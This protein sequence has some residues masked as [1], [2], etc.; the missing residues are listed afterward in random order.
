M[1]S[2]FHIEPVED[3]VAVGAVD[4]SSA[5]I[6][7]RSEV[8]GRHIVEVLDG[9]AGRRVEVDV[10]TA[11]ERC[12]VAVAVL[13][14]LQPGRR[15]EIV[16]RRP[17]DTTWPERELGR[18]TF[19]TAPASPTAVERFS[20]G[21][22]SCH[23][24]FDENGDV[25]PE[26]RA[27]LA[28]TNR[29]L[30]ERDAAFVLML[31]DQMYSDS[32]SSRSLF[33][34]EHF[35]TVAPKGRDALLDCDAAEVRRLYQDRY[36]SFFALPEW[37]E[38]LAAR[39]CYPILDDHEVIDNWGS[40]EDHATSEWHAVRRGALDAYRD[41]Q[42][43]RVRDRDA[44]PE[45]ALHYDF[46]YGPV[47]VMVT[48]MRTRRSIGDG[49]LFGAE[50]V[51]AIERF[52][53]EHRDLPIAVLGTSLPL[54]H[55][56][57]Q[58]ASLGAMLTGDGDD[59]SD[60]AIHPAFRDEYR[61]VCGILRTHVE[62]NPKQQLVLASGDIHLGAICELRW[63]DRATALQL[64]SSGITREAE[65]AVGLLSSLAL[66]ASHDEPEDR[67]DHPQADVVESDDNPLLDRNLGLIEIERDAR[68]DWRAGL[69]LY[70]PGAGMLRRAAS[71]RGDGTPSH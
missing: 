46:E 13:D 17:A 26:A 52:L 12:N 67:E 59:F 2:S 7:L 9:G 58:A 42:D 15:H 53:R 30:A 14:G 50:Q 16:V 11:P 71:L 48:D 3:L 40:D 65:A 60:R 61:R 68:G 51:E 38:L 19:R 31:G 54:F 20:I 5:R 70:G 10:P 64:I 6:W 34:A 56:P 45:G 4:T 32:P 25:Q 22:M 57:R 66:E 23:Q 33:D 37:R 1:T 21:V 41:F 49:T 43:S 35:R 8:P 36:R 28:G 18:A 69:A 39:P 63:S 44:R 24:P 27:M 62:R 29:L 47:A 55:V